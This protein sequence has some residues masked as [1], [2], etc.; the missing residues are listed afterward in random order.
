[1]VHRIFKDFDEESHY[2]FIAKDISEHI[3]IAIDEIENLKGYHEIIGIY[4]DFQDSKETLISV[5]FNDEQD[6]TY[7]WDFV[8]NYHLYY[9]DDIPKIIFWWINKWGTAIR[10]EWGKCVNFSFSITK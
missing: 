9:K 5:H 6:T 10:D 4:V 3:D 2:Y 1:M 7:S 8:N